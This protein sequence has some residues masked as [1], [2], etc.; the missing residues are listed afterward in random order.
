LSLLT[1]LKLKTPATRR[2]RGGATV[3]DSP[4][5]FT[6]LLAGNT[7][8][9][10]KPR[11]RNFT[12]AKVLCDFGLKTYKPGSTGQMIVNTERGFRHYED[13]QW[14]SKAEVDE[15]I[16]DLISGR[17]KTVEMTGGFGA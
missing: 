6:L 11:W 9:T 4:R 1:A 2:L 12:M 7:A 8:N 13:Y 5:V 17:I 10:I 14:Y 15:L 16:F 3:A